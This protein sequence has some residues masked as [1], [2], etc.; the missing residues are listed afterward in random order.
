MAV[1]VIT[2]PTPT[3]TLD[4]TPDEARHIRE[5]Q[6][7]GVAVYSFYA[8]TVSATAGGDPI[9][10]SNAQGSLNRLSDETGGRAFFQGT[11][12]PVSFDPFLRDL[13]EMLSSQYALTYLSARPD[14]GFRRIKVET[15]VPNVRVE[16]PS[17]YVR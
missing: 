9:L 17:G 8:P 12:A 10:V 6:R 11:G 13:K 16:H 2:D 14:R 4:L 7:R 1:T 15:E 3:L 5:A